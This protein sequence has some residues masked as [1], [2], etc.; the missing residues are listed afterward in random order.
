[1]R[2]PLGPTRGSQDPRTGLPDRGPGGRR[3]EGTMGYVLFLLIAFAM[4]GVQRTGRALHGHVHH[5]P[6]T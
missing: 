3:L 5:H 6:E 4:L 2:Q 1:M